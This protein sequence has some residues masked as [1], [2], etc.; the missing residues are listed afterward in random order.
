MGAG[1][2]PQQGEREGDQQVKCGGGSLT[3]RPFL[4]ELGKRE[5]VPVRHLEVPAEVAGLLQ[6]AAAAAGV[7]ALTAAGKG[8]G[9][10]CS[11]YMLPLS[12]GLQ[13]SSVPR[14]AIVRTPRLQAE[15]CVTL[16][17]DINNYP[18]AKFIRCHFKV[19]AGQP[20]PWTLK[21]RANSASLKASAVW[22]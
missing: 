9:E 14:V 8:W 15:P 12:A 5:V 4:Q 2:E 1:S 13:L 6:A 19:S 17:L 7:L 18:M 22:A 21:L 3:P 20:D 10:E 16:P 11:H